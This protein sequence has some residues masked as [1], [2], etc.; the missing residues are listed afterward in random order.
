MPPIKNKSPDPN[1]IYTI[2]RLNREV[3]RVLED[4]FPAIWVQGEISNLAKP[5]SGHLYFTLKDNA[6]QVRCAMFKNRQSGLRFDPEN[7]M[8]VMA[9]A[10][11]GLYEGRGEYQLIINSLEPAGA[12]ALQIAFEA[13]KQKLSSE[14][15]F[16]E[17]HK[18]PLPIFPETIGI[19]TSATGAA[20]QDILSILRRRYPYGKV[21]IY[22]VPVQ[23][24][25]A[26]IKIANAI[27]LAEQRKECNV[28]ILSRGGGSLE[29]LWSFNEEIVARAIFNADTPIVSGIGH[30]IDFT[31][32]DFVADH[33]APTPSA[34]AELVSPD[35]IE[36]VAKL[37]QREEQLA[38]YQNQIIHNLKRHIE[39]LSA[40]VP[41]PQ[42]RLIELMQRTD[43]FSM[44]IRHQIENELSHKKIILSTWLNKISELN[45]V[46]Q[47]S[48][49]IEK[50]KHIQSQ[51]EQSIKLILNKSNNDISRL[52]HML[53]TVSPISTLDRGYA[54]VTDKK[55]NSVVT[56]IKHLNAGDQLRI[57][58]STAEIDSTI[59]KIHED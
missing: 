36:T 6:A 2:S 27:K 22:P 8:Q 29:D 56:G 4:V 11:I 40:Q 46:H 42:Q 5:A 37:K 14:G 15:L 52:N 13:L 35:V 48:Q 25:G 10:N 3:R 7:G 30:E 16:A 43:E 1:D 49:Q 17:E 54:I 59:D 19:I 50:V 26:A 45:P 21:I 23:G 20:V 31:I 47:V 51:F 39:L 24:E 44:R 18:K 28:L 41:H 33:R 58:L 55:T 57:R 38:R 53:N 9:R 12:G 34:A 32:A